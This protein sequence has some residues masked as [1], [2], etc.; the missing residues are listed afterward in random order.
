MG[1]LGGGTGAKSFS[2]MVRRK[3]SGSPSAAQNRPL[4]EFMEDRTCWRRRC[5]PRLAT[6]AFQRART[7]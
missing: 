1:F 2:T 4:V 3:L 5:C 7:N 6:R